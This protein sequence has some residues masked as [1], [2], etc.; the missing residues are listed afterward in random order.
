MVGK[1]FPAG[2]GD[3]E[4][5]EAGNQ[6]P[7]SLITLCIVSFWGQM[8]LAQAFLHSCHFSGHE[9]LMCLSQCPLTSV[10][11]LFLHGFLYETMGKRR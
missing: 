1:H 11:W 10:L 5:T 6:H 9:F 4:Q 2:G 3:T 7:L 8:V